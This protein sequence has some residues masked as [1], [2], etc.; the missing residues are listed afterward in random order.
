ML[1]ICGGLQLL[2]G[3]IED[4]AGVDGSGTGLGLLAG[5]DGVPRGEADGAGGDGLR[6]AAR[7]LA[8]AVRARGARVRDPPRRGRADR[9]TST[10]AL[11]GGRGFVAGSVLGL[12]LH[13]VLESPDVVA[14]LVGRSPT[15]GLEAVFD[16]LADLVEERL[17]VDALGRLAGVA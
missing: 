11:P 16:D 6:G 9:R 5:A 2:G 17:D 15:R 1:G 13:G 8:G 4:P 7:A 10:E 14:S 3:A 12:T